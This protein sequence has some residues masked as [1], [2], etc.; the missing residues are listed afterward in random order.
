MKTEV[1]A[2]EGDMGAVRDRLDAWTRRSRFCLRV[3]GRVYRTQ[4]CG[5][6][7]MGLAARPPSGADDGYLD[8]G[9]VVG[10]Y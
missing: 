3:L 1:I 4:T 9:T 2:A 10:V 5:N 7:P 8:T 6:T